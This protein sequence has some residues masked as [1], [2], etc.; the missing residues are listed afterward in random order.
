LN[1]VFKNTLNLRPHGNHAPP[2]PRSPSGVI[3]TAC[4]RRPAGC[5]PMPTATN[6]IL[7]SHSDLYRRG[8]NR[9]N[10]RRITTSPYSPANNFCGR[11]HDFEPFATDGIQSFRQPH[12]HATA[13]CDKPKPTGSKSKRNTCR[14][15]T[16]K[17]TRNSNDSRKFKPTQSTTA[18]PR[19]TP[20]FGRRTHRH[21]TAASSLPGL[22]RVNP[23]YIGIHPNS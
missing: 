13:A 17:P 16:P 7:H 23:A 5:A 20:G 21:P 3:A 9:K 2:S 4:R 19:R 18:T 8:Q 6:A 12:T 11:C 14:T 15:P 1:N 22:A 10:H